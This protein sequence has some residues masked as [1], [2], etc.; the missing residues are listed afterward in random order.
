MQGEAFLADN[1]VTA[2]QLNGEGGRAGDVNWRGGVNTGGTRNSHDGA[3][4]TLIFRS[5]IL[6][7]RTL[8]QLEVS[9][10]L[11]GLV[12][13][14]NRMVLTQPLIH[15]ASWIQQIQA[16]LLPVKLAVWK[17]A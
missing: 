7:L 16:T 1:G 5:P 2:G 10:K 9:S 13:Q 17:T 11:T 15:Q 12:E 8:Q 3:H 4:S 6:T 14:E